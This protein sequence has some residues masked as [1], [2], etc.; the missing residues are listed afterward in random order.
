MSDCC[1]VRVC[2]REKDAA[3]FQKIFWPDTPVNHDRVPPNDGEEKLFIEL[4]YEEVNYGGV[5]E[6]EEAARA[7]LFFFGIHHRGDDYEGEKFC[8]WRCA[9]H[10]HTIDIDGVLTLA[11]DDEDDLRDSKRRWKRFLH[12]YEQAVR[13]V[14]GS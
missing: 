11:A 8:S 1:F 12:V 2:V 14:R 4:E 3:K 10:M 6:L 9:L 13:R 7:G 5:N